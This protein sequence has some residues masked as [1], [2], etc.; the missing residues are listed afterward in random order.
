MYCTFSLHSCPRFS[1]TKTPRV[2]K[3]VWGV[4]EDALVRTA[5]LLHHV[6]SLT[7]A[8]PPEPLQAPLHAKSG[9]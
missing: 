6:V 1:T 4:P 8:Q 9:T 7:R 3:V 5:I 2:V